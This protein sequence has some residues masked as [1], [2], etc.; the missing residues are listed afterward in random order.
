MLNDTRGELQQTFRAA[1]G[2]DISTQ[3]INPFASARLWIWGCWLATHT[4]ESTISK[5]MDNEIRCAEPDKPHFDFADAQEKIDFNPHKDTNTQ[6][7]IIKLIIIC[8]QPLESDLQEQCWLSSSTILPL[9]SAYLTLMWM[10]YCP[11]HHITN[12]RGSQVI[13][14]CVFLGQK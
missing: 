2:L 6:D 7:D 14:S 5:W 1:A 9:F 12:H 11:L 8:Y 4:H 13:H 3:A 10:L